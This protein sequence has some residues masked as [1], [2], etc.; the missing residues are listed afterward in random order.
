[1]KPFA[2]TIRA[3]LAAAGISLATT[4][5]PLEVTAQDQNTAFVHG[6]Y[7]VSSWDYAAA[8]LNEQFRIRPFVPHLSWTASWSDQAAQ[9]NVNVPGTGIVAAGYS[10]GAPVSREFNRAFGRNNKIVTLVGANSGAPAAANVL[11]GMAYYY[12][13]SLAV[14]IVDPVAYY[15]YW[16]AQGVE[17]AVG[18]YGLLALS[19]VF[20]FARYIPNL[21][22]GQGFITGQFTGG[23][24]PVL[25]D[26]SPNSAAVATLNSS[27]NLTREAGAMSARVGI[28]SAFP[29]PINQQFYFLAPGHVG[30]LITARR[31]GWG[32]SVAAFLYYEFWISPNREYYSQLH[33][34]SVLWARSALWI[35][36]MDA[37]WCA[38]TGTLQQYTRYGIFGYSI[39]CS[40]SDALIPV[41]YQ[42]YPSGTRQYTLTNGPPHGIV[43]FT[44]A[45]LTAMRTTFQTDFGVGARSASDPTSLVLSPATVGVQEGAARSLVATVKNVWGT[46]LPS[47]AVTW[48]NTA[49]GVATLSPSGQGANVQGVSAGTTRIIASANGYADTSVVTVTAVQP[50]AI[51]DLYGPSMSTQ[52]SWDSFGVS[53][54]G[55]R[56]PLSYEWYVD[57][58]LQ[59]NSNSST[60]GFTNQGSTY[61]VTV[62]VRDAGGASQSASRAVEVQNCGGP[63]IC[64]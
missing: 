13:G 3:A 2:L 50:L 18:Y 15:A 61:T 25:R 4:A 20:N 64:D 47:A 53:T 45:G 34:G 5:L 33:A 58:V 48:T 59:A 22:A 7:Q 57:G 63:I 38:I 40:A 6:L 56:D 55:G 35:M 54:T 44:T 43:P 19:Y 60:F 28:V 31:W 41:A 51:T 8:R 21:L 9:L 23:V 39:A 42:Q 17:W 29:T 1:V 52:Y 62:V 32:A 10:N 49:P 30:S 37:W 12:A 24:L 16:E 36:D 46:T 11:N 26:L 14:A 27:A